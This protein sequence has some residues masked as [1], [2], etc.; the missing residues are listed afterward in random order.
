[1][2]L[3]GGGTDRGRRD[4]RKRRWSQQ[5]SWTGG[6]PQANIVREKRNLGPNRNLQKGKLPYE[7]EGVNQSD[8]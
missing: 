4:G 5:R 3:K 7:I 6:G 2:S 1:M 8:E